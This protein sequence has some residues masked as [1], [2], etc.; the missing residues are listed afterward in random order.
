MTSAAEGGLLA[1]ALDA[2]FERTHFLYAVYTVVGPGRHSPLPP[3]PLPGSRGPARRARRAPRRDPGGG[4]AGG[5]AGRRAGRPAVCRVRR[6][7]ST[8]RTPALASYSGK[9]CASTPTAR[10][11]QISPRATRC[12]RP[13]FNRPADWIGIP[14][15]ARCG[16]PMSS[17]ATSKNC[18]SSSPAGNGAPSPT[19][20]DVVAGSDR[21][22]GAGLLSR[23]AVAGVRRRSLRG[24]RGGRAPAAAALRQRAIPRGSSR[25]SA[26][27]RTPT[28]ASGPWRPAATAW[29]TSRPTARSCALGPR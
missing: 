13:T 4:A 8:G 3:G 22:R 15:P 29:S 16:W 7:A 27:C 21:C 11:R 24:G 28:A 12:S 6:G 26:C 18:A 14:R 10:H 2:Q 9:S 20:A 23:H 17:G 25:A 1:L 19:H 5:G